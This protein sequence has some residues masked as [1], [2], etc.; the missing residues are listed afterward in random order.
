MI[1]IKESETIEINKFLQN[2]ANTAAKTLSSNLDNELYKN[3]NLKILSSESV[4]SIID[5]KGEDIFFK[6]DFITG[7][8]ES[9]IALI[10]PEELI[11]YLTDIVMGGQGKEFKGSLSE[12]EVNAA[13]NLF[14]KNFKDI[15][16]LFKHNYSN[17]LV[18]STTPKM[19][20]KGSP[21]YDNE[22]SVL[23]FDFMV[24]QTL[25][26]S[27]D[28]EFPIILLLKFHDLKEM[29]MEMRLLNSDGPIKTFETDSIDIDKISDVKIDITAE[30]GKTQIPIKYAL[31][32][33][34]GSVV[35]LDTLINSDIKVYANGIE[36]ANAQVVAIEDSFALKI[37]KIISP[38][39]RLKSI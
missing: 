39:E 31:E 35:E 30:L 12:I 9:S 13:L 38:E 1:N 29:L 3:L 14:E 21:E 24:S 33:V 8:Y 6:S 19:L 36:V 37:T 26:I 4:D 7:K 16:E 5:Y 20:L 10:V 23:K 2:F 27:E 17:S 18:F 32:L 34:R 28:K 25:Q 11:A 15:E 22:F